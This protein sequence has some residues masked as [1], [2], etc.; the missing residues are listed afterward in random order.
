MD[1]NGKIEF[2]VGGSSYY[3]GIGGTKVYWFE[4]DGNN[5]YNK[6]YTF[7][8]SG[9]DVLGITEMYSY[10]VNAD[11]IDDLVFAFS[12]SV[13]IL[14]WNSDGYFELFYLDWLEDWDKEI[15]SVNIYDTYNTGRPDLY[16]SYNDYHKA[17]AVYS[18][19]FI[20]NFITGITENIPTI[21]KEVRLFQNYPNPFNNS[22]IIK[23]KL[24]KP[25]IVNLK[26]MDIN[27]REVIILSKNKS[28]GAGNNEIRWN[29]K[30]KFG[31]EV[32]SGI[33]LYV[34]SN[35]KQTLSGKM[36]LIK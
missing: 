4:A 21:L 27:G 31:K 17:P 26:I 15:H 23:F 22:T 19:Y 3:N 5:N 18:D 25:Q 35:G 30:N 8:L 14:I 9:T 16:I 2:F 24:N 7:F 33:Y 1:N 10:D 20:N 12:G 11:N 13:V 34:I 36:L 29:G 32:S 28:Y 6:K